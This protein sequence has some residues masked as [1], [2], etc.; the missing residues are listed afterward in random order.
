MMSRDRGRRPRP[1]RARGTARRWRSGSPHI[2]R[3]LERRHRLGVGSALGERVGGRG[4]LVDV[5][6][7]GQ[8]W[9]DVLL[10]ELG[11]ELPA[12]VRVGHHH[13]GARGGLRSQLRADRSAAYRIGL[14][15][16][17]APNAARLTS[18]AALP[19]TIVAGPRGARARCRGP[20]QVVAAHLGQV[21]GSPRSPSAGVR[22]HGA[23]A[24][25]GRRGPGR[26]APRRPR[27]G[28]ATRCATGRRRCR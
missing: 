24:A 3:A 16:G 26:P 4:V 21:A 2:A 14:R 19:S 25:R 15:S 11:D 8:G 18:P 7:L 13:L 17:R 28:R 22:A 27:R 6:G 10:R 12:P 9:A 1:V 23:V 20:G 5:L